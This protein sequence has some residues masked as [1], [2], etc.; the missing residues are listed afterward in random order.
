MIARE[1]NEFFAGFDAGD[2]DAPRCSARSTRTPHPGFLSNVNAATAASVLEEIRFRDVRLLR[3]P[4]VRRDLLAAG[5]LKVYHPR[6]CGAARP[7]LPLARVHAPLLRRVPRA[8]RDDRPRRADRH[9]L[10]GARRSRPVA[11]DRAFDGRA[12]HR[13][14]ASALRWSAR[15]AAHH[16]GRRVVLRARLA[17]RAPARRGAARALARGSRRRAGGRRRRQRP[18]P[19]HVAPVRSREVFAEVL[20]SEAAGAGAAAR[21]RSRDGRPRRGCT[22]RW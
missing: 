14:Q 20:A 9:P 19:A 22:W 3:G 17:R 1:L 21:A 13:R 2:P 8:A 12:G 15:S 6:R 7:R 10:D 18:A 16:G 11:D 4:G 5:W